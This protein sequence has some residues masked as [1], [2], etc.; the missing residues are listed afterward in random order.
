M[1]KQKHAYVLA[2]TAVLFWSTVASAFKISLQRLDFLQLLF[3]ASAVSIVILLAILCIENK[4]FC[5]RVTR[6]KN[7]FV[8]LCLVF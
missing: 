3:Y 1:E 7:I 8:R 6:R 2:F 5:F 4:L